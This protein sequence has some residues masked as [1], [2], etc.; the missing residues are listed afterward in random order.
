[1]KNLYQF[2]TTLFCLQILIFSSAGFS[3]A[4]ETAPAFEVPP[5]DDVVNPGFEVVPPS[6]GEVISILPLDEPPVGPSEETPK[7][8]DEGEEGSEQESTEEDTDANVGDADGQPLSDQFSLPD[9]ERPDF[10]A[11]PDDSQTFDHVS[12]P[13]QFP[14]L[15]T[16]S[17]DEELPA[18]L[19][20]REVTVRALE[21]VTARTEDIV[22]PIGQTVAFHSINILLRT[23]EKRPPE[24]P[25]ETS[26]FI[27]VSEERLDG[28]T[29]TYFSGW[30]FAS[31]PGLNG[32]EHP[33]YDIW[34]ID[35]KISEPV[36][37]VGKE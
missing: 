13:P 21:K 1:M 28:E 34:V 33:V 32:L 12:V 7:L 10:F 5:E 11:L 8:P 9:T 2:G 14:D 35:C 25:P 31:S 15:T 24:E 17:P 29:V 37:P 16:A 3:Q 6:Q 20:Y 36:E 22:I 30:M 19:T 23:C 4:Q 27:E 18:P 26:A